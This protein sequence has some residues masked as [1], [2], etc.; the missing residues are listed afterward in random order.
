[1]SFIEREEHR[2][3]QFCGMLYCYLNQDIFRSSDAA[4]IVTVTRYSWGTQHLIAII[5]QYLCE[6]IY[7]LFGTNGERKVN[8]TLTEDV[9]F[10][11]LHLWTGH[12]FQPRIGI[13]ETQDIRF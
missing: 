1:M 7:T 6:I 5:V 3:S 8:E 9:L 11:V 12:Q 13:L 10:L 4:L 2:R